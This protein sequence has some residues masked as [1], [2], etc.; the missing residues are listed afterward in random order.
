MEEFSESCH[1]LALL[2]SERVANLSYA[3]LACS[4][5]PVLRPLMFCSHVFLWKQGP[6]PG[7]VD[8]PVQ[9]AGA[10]EAHRGRGRARDRRG[11][12]E[13]EHAVRGGVPRVSAR[14]EGAVT[15]CRVIL[16]F[17]VPC[18]LVRIRRTRKLFFFCLTS[19]V[20]VNTVPLVDIP[21]VR[22]YVSE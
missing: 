1:A 16:V 3:S 9:P 6:D 2:A 18:F 12:P 19:G 7:G 14:H 21:P 11:R 4:P 22:V 10:A 20:R 13:A 8:P 5:T 15:S 17:L